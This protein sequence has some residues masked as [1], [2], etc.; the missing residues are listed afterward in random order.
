MEC[1]LELKET[2]TTTGNLSQNVSKSSNQGKEVWN[3]LFLRG[4]AHTR[5]STICIYR[6][7]HSG[8]I[9]VCWVHTYSS[10]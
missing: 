2:T 9:T 3:T 5:V 7:T 10:G 6:I 8:G 4:V 1:G